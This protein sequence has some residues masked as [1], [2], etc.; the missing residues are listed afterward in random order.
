MKYSWRE[1][2]VA[3]EVIS[4]RPMADFYAKFM[5]KHGIEF[6]SEEEQRNK[7]GGSTDMGN[8]S[9]EMPVIHPMFDIHTTSANHTIDFVNASKTEEAHKEA[10]LA[11][12][13][14]ALTAVE[15]LANEKFY[16]SVQKNFKETM[17]TINKRNV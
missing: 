17:A 15:V 10:I 2:G 13:A 9:Y 14:L 1:A 5:N 7:A 4:N 6:P 16:T 12:K 3:K 8:V 11:S